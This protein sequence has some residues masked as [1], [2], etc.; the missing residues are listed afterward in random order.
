MS[1]VGF[2]VIVVPAIGGNA[3][4]GSFTGLIVPLQQMGSVT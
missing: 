3:W 4:P 2:V 1:V